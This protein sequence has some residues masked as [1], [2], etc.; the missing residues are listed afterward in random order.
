M[1]SLNTFVFL[2]IVREGSSSDE[3]FPLRA[4]VRSHL[5]GC[6]SGRSICRSR[7]QPEVGGEVLLGDMDFQ[8]HT[9]NREVGQPELGRIPGLQEWPDVSD[10]SES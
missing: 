8:S 3:C 9:W 5:F 1:K 10:L 6:R 7:Y 2:W 4:T